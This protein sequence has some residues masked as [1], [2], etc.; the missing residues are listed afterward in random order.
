MH[1]SAQELKTYVSSHKLCNFITDGC[2]LKPRNS[3]LLLDFS[4]VSNCDSECTLQFKRRSGNGRMVIRSNGTA[5]RA[6][7][8]AI[9]VQGVKTPLGENKQVEI[10]RVMDC[11]GDLILCGVNFD[12][13]K[14]PQPAPAQTEPTII[15]PQEAEWNT[16]LKFCKGSKGLKISNDILYASEGAVLNDAAKISQVETEPPNVTKREGKKLKFIYPCQVLSIVINDDSYIKDEKYVHLHHPTTVV[17]VLPRITERSPPVESRRITIKNIY[18][19]KGLDLYQT[20]HKR[21]DI[22][23]TDNGILMKRNGRFCIPIS[24]LSSHM[25]YTLV[26]TLYKPNGNGK[27]NLSF[28]DKEGGYKDTVTIVAPQ[29]LQEVTTHLH[30]GSSNGKSVL[31]FHRLSKVAVGNVLIQRIQIVN[32]V[33]AQHFVELSVN[34]DHTTKTPPPRKSLLRKT[35]DYSL[36]CVNEDIKSAFKHYAVLEPSKYKGEVADISCPMQIVGS[37]AEQWF[38]KISPIF[39]KITN[40]H[41]ANIAVCSVADLVESTVVWIEEF[42]HNVGTERLSKL[43]SA[44]V[45]CTPSLVNMFFLKRCFPEKNI[46]LQHRPWPT[47]GPR[48]KDEKDYFIYFEKDSVVTNL[49]LNLW[50]KN[51]GTLYMVGIRKSVPDYVRYISEYEPYP[52]LYKK[53]AG[54]RGVID[55]H[56]NSHYISGILELAKAL[57][58]PIITNNHKYISYT[59]FIIRNSRGNK[60]YYVSA[61]DIDR[62]ISRCVGSGI[63]DMPVQKYSIKQVMSKFLEIK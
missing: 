5:S 6:T 27:L 45:V 42:D 17:S 56:P 54:A 4:S 25:L 2:I 35:S 21:D 61:H 34:V 19:S 52:E 3:M 49:L 8:R 26:I 44:N 36:N 50:K 46:Q 7:A 48:K 51:Y 11:S 43:S 47:L 38:N 63:T 18:D 10:L 39:P 9:T 37:S 41:D 53:I 23:R 55:I 15:L 58:I 30:S 29:T 12:K 24:Q 13:A 20:A 31:Q 14:K 60:E 28:M 62:V 32:A 22:E 16:I 59:Q 33:P 57:G 40:R 1:I